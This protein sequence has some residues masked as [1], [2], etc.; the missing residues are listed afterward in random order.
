MDR[1]VEEEVARLLAEAKAL[2]EA[3][4]ER[5]AVA[6]AA[7]SSQTKGIF[8]QLPVLDVLTAK[9]DIVL[10]ASVKLVD[11]MNEA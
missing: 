11:T 8:I 4:A 7:S 3:E 10:D 5:K 6:D 2:A 9:V 1:Q